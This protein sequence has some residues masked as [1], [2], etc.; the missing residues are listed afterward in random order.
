MESA[1]AV[2]VHVTARYRTIKAQSCCLRK[3]TMPLAML[4]MLLVIFAR[5][6]TGYLMEKYC[7]VPLRYGCGIDQTQQAV[8]FGLLTSFGHETVSR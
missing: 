1:W 2:C 8:H 6:V 7:N 4:S 3:Q 5:R